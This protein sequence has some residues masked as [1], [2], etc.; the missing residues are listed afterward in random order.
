MSRFCIDRCICF[1]RGFDELLQI[2]KAKQLTTLE[3]LQQEAEFGRSC[4]LCH[5]YIRRML[6]TGERSFDVLLTQDDE[7]PSKT[8]KG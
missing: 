6:R 7:P 8:E 5:P 2:A 4:R 3:Q 1:G